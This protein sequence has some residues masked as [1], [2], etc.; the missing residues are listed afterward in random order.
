[1][2]RMPIAAVVAA[3]AVFLAACGGTEGAAPKPPDTLFLRSADGITLVRTRP[4]AVAVRFAGAVPSIDWSAVVR[5]SSKGGGTR[6]EALDAS[7]GTRLWTRD[8]P[9]SLEVKVASPE[10]RLVALGTPR[11]GTGYPGG[12]ASTTLVIVGANSARPRTIH[13]TGNFEPEAFSTDGRS[14]FVIQYMPAKAPTHYRVRRLDLGTEQVTGVYTVDAELQRSMRGT[15]RVQAASP[16][17]SRLYTLYSID[18]AGGTSHSFIHVLSLDEEWAHCVDLPATFGTAADRSIAL[19]VAPDGRRLYVA[20]SATGAVAEVDTQALR[21][22]LSEEVGFGSAGQA[23]YAARGSDGVL[24]VAAG[25]RVM[26]VDTRSLTPQRWWDLEGRITGLQAGAGGRLYVGLKDRI[27]AL[28]TATGRQVAVLDPAHTGT[29]RQLGQSTVT[30]DQK[31]TDI[32]CA[33]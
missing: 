20:D 10:A 3:A 21:V 9:G 5:A 17:G 6:L 16:D 26:A 31:R 27:M 32:T 29:I 11:R 22:T 13:L 24:Y 18:G 28:D 12:R 33:C 1:M 14:L 19:S 4:Q 23:A 7:S 15:A 25:K 30:L 8:V 2:R